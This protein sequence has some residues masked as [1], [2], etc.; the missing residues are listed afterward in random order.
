MG[1]LKPWHVLC[2]LFCMLSVTGI[3]AAVLLI[4]SRR[5]PPS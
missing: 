3:V 2:L 1:A 4:T 5:R